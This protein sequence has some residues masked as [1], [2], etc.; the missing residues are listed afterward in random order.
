MIQKRP[1]PFAK[2]ALAPMQMMA[3][4]LIAAELNNFPIKLKT[5]IPD[6]IGIAACGGPEMRRKIRI[7]GRIGKAQSQ[8]AR[9]VR[10]R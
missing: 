8:I 5:A 2:A 4:I 6:A 7:G 9:R 1:F 10:P 3:T